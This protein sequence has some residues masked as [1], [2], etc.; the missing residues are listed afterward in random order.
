MPVPDVAIYCERYIPIKHVW[1]DVIVD[2]SGGQW[3]LESGVIVDTDNVTALTMT[4]SPNVGD[5]FV[6]YFDGSQ[7][8]IAKAFF[9]E[10]YVDLTG[11]ANA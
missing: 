1:A 9:E 10:A 8:W 6:Q 5:Y 2:I 4:N 3:T 11:E 7:C